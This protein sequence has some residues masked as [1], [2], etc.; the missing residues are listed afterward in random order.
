MAGKLTAQ[1]ERNQTPDARYV[2]YFPR[3]YPTPE[4]HS[5]TKIYQSIQYISHQLYHVLVTFK[6]SNK[7]TV[8]TIAT[9]GCR[10]GSLHSHARVGHADRQRLHTTGYSSSIPMLKMRASIRSEKDDPNGEV[11]NFGRIHL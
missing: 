5:S 2:V 7:K 9:D 6:Q 8:S 10:F 1:N 11:F 3:T 4:H